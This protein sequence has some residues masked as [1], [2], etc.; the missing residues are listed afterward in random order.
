MIDSSCCR[1]IGSRSR[2]TINYKTHI[3]K[4]EIQRSKWLNQKRPY[5][6]DKI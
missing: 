6:T 1:S 4:S 2:Y 5:G 3:S